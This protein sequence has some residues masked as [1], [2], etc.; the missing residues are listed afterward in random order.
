MPKHPY[1]LPIEI[2]DIY[3][4]K[5]Q[6]RP[7]YLFIYK[8]TI[9]I[10]KTNTPILKYINELINTPLSFSDY[11]SI[12]LTDINNTFDEKTKKADI[13]IQGIYT[14]TI[15]KITTNINNIDINHTESVI[16][17]LLS[18]FL[19][20]LLED[21]DNSNL[22]ALS[23]NYEN[24]KTYITNTYYN[25]KLSL[26]TYNNQT[27]KY[28]TDTLVNNADILIDLYKKYLYSD[29][30]NGDY[31]K[32][33]S[34]L[35]SVNNNS[36][37]IIEPEISSVTAPSNKSNSETS[38]QNRVNMANGVVLTI[39]VPATNTFSSFNIKDLYNIIQDERQ[40]ED[41]KEAKKEDKKEDKEEHQKEDQKIINNIESILTPKS[42]TD[43]GFRRAKQ[44][45]CSIL[46]NVGPTRSSK[47]INGKKYNIILNPDR[48]LK[49]SFT[50]NVTDKIKKSLKS[51]PVDIL[52]TNINKVQES[53]NKFLS[54]KLI[55]NSTGEDYKYKKDTTNTA[56]YKNH[57]FIELYSDIL[58][59]KDIILN[60]IEKITN[61][62]DAKVFCDDYFIP[63]IND[64]STFFN[65]YGTI[66]YPPL[67]NIRK[68]INIV[69]NQFSTILKHNTNMSQEDIDTKK[70]I[71]WSVI[72][73]TTTTDDKNLNSYI[74]NYLFDNITALTKDYSIL[75]FSTI[76]P[77]FELLDL[78]VNN[79]IH[80]AVISIMNVV[81][82][83]L[84]SNESFVTYY[85]EKYNVDLTL[86][87]SSNNYTLEPFI[88]LG[89]VSK[90]ET[91][92]NELDDE[93]LL[94]TLHQTKDL[95]NTIDAV[96]KGL[97]AFLPQGYVLNDV[98]S[99]K[100]L[101]SFP[102]VLNSISLLIKN[103]YV[104]CKKQAE[105]KPLST[106]EQHKLTD[107]LSVI[108]GNYLKIANVL[109]VAKSVINTIN[110]YD[111]EY[112]I[113]VNGTKETIPFM[114]LLHNNYVL[115]EDVD[116]QIQAC[117]YNLQVA[118]TILASEDSSE[119]QKENAKNNKEELRDKIT[120]LQKYK[121]KLDTIESMHDLITNTVTVKSN[122]QLI[123]DVAEKFEFILKTNNIP[124]KQPASAATSSGTQNNT[125]NTSQQVVPTTVKTTEN[126][127][128]TK[129]PLS[130]AN[131]QVPDIQNKT[132]PSTK[133][134]IPN[135]IISDGKPFVG[136]D[137][138]NHVE[139]EV[140][141]KLNPKSALNYSNL[142]L[143]IKNK[144]NML[145]N[146]QKI[147]K[148]DKKQLADLDNK[149]NNYLYLFNDEDY[150]V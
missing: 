15:Q 29:K 101:H 18:S 66:V 81:I 147:S 50:P 93:L 104:L 42:K 7:T 114:D 11:I 98:L 122:L 120:D 109:Y 21:A 132:I 84:L 113:T 67:S 88:N 51:T 24:S 30:N 23:P 26:T 43:L 20:K 123:N 150:D 36:N 3:V 56:F 1:R 41:Q 22:P 140:S 70:S 38:K 31:N 19:Y 85:K 40:K 60:N 133:T 99:I 139:D 47:T 92:I 144:A 10:N 108:S 127:T 130:P 68:N 14:N 44:L 136:G 116:S 16:N 100:D 105:N 77:F 75:S 106:E 72:C 17:S 64:V 82:K 28:N 52:Y 103:T 5:D 65:R 146:A 111:E 145:I 149:I 129:L 148:E 39:P 131:K 49:F 35:L 8:I 135:N 58:D 61:S 27:T 96:Y 83:K 69:T 117:T 76:S 124:E 73:N 34:Y 89:V 2:Q 126:Q 71:L 48:N 110:N 32:V 143:L 142:E 4:D 37:T 63:F 87:S 79:K 80:N 86:L 115:Q 112:F 12:V 94:D 97:F 13:Y 62:E 9:D 59:T 138:S 57:T 137:I 125:N 91:D 46:S 95:F 128:F 118:E 102:K 107:Y 25:F 6:T 78:I 55:H 74:Y 53:L 54:N 33:G 119:T 134:H 90:P 121:D 141:N 45:F